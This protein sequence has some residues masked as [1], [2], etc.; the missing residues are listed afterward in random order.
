MSEYVP[1]ALRRLVTER[2]EGYCEYCGVHADD[3]T[4]PHEPDHVFATKHGGETTADN[5]ALACFVCNRFKGTDLAS[6]DPQTDQ[7]VRLF[8]PRRDTWADHFRGEPNGVIEPL[9][10]IGRVTARLLQFNLPESV[11]A[12][13]LL[14]EAGRYGK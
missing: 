14:I 11:E 2:A 4:L 13:R 8:H 3:V 12:R 10:D 7:V 6:I 5:L 1:A 9:T